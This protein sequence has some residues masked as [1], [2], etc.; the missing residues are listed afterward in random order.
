MDYPLDPI[1]SIRERRGWFLGLGI[2]LILLGSGVIGSSY[3][4]TVFSVIL[5]GL[6]LIFA[7]VVQIVQAILARKWSAVFLALFLGVLY[8][9]TGALCVVSP[10]TA[11]VGITL[12]IAA[13]CLIAGSF[14]MLSAL[15]L[16]FARWE[17]VFASG[18]ITFLLGIMIY[19]DWPLSGLWVIGL[20]VGIEMVLSGCAWI[21]LALS[22]AQ[23]RR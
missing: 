12:W 19:A 15:L 14:R 2:V 7:G 23:L 22:H 1:G 17:W 4:A 18:V 10:T 8:V 6:F 9:V 11:A 13:F 20:F 21:A 5:L 16:R 3:Y